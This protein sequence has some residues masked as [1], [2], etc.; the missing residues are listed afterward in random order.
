MGKPVVK[1]LTGMRRVGKSYVLR[2]L[3]HDY[4]ERGIADA[5]ICFVDKESLDF[6]AIKTA[7]DLH[8][9]AKK[10]WGQ[11]KK[12]V[13]LVDEVQEIE[14]WEKAVVSLASL[15]DVDIVVTGSNAQLFSSELAT[16]LGGRCIEFMIHNLSW[17]EF[18]QF[19]GASAG[20]R[21][22]EFRLYLRYGGLPALHHMEWKDD[23]AF[24]YLG[25][26][27]NH[28]VLKDIVTRHEVRDVALLDRIGSFLLD[29]VGQVVSANR[30][31]AY[32]KSQ[33]LKVGVDTVINYLGYYQQALLARKVVRFD[34]PGKRMLEIHE[35]YYMS[36]T[37]L[38]HARL[39]YR[40]SE[41]AGVLE[42]IVYLELLRR[43]YQVY[44][45]KAGDR[46]VDFVA[47]K[48]QRL[49][50]LQ[51]ASTL[52][53]PA[54]AEREYVPLRGIRDN[55]PK[56]VLSMDAIFDEDRGGVRWMNLVD[57]LEGEDG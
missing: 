29:N 23:V 25:A 50:Y 18:V 42:N 31:A 12:R 57:W 9:F 51:V 55:Y 43:G 56:M 38:R 36:D 1:V 47:M 4:R 49:A 11:R 53:D 10:S 54:V 34:I 44:I 7:K 20:P 32:F 16:K 39:G 52:A 48:D 33:R 22:R 8:V 27:F 3:Y 19:R 15:P 28:I 40:E 37:G 35:K 24:Q 45:G 21:E 2:Q 30:I 14:A 46:E 17:R 26:I 41:L 5:A 6:E 13:L